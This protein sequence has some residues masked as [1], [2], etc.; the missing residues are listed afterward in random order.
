[1]GTCQ[2]VLDYLIPYVNE[3]TAFGEPISHRQAVAFDVA[4]VAIELEGMSL[5]RFLAWA[6]RELGREVA[7]GPALT[8]TDLASVVVHGSTEGLTPGEAL[9]A[10]LATTRFRAELVGERIIITPRDPA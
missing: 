7:F 4:N 1:M 3:R 8:D 2:A 10:V 5:S 9:G 6:A